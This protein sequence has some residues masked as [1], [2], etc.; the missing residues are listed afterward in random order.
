M[1]RRRILVSAYA[2]EPGKGSE[3]GVGWQWCLQLAQLADLVVLT[4]A[5][6]RSAIEGS[7][8]AEL[9]GKISFIYHDPPGWVLR[10][11]HREK[12][13]YWFYLLWQWGA[14][15]RARHAVR[16]QRF[17]YT[18]HLTFGSIWMPTFFHRLPVPFIWGPIGGGEAVPLSVIPALPP[19]GRIVQYLRHVLMACVPFNPLLTNVMARAAVI[20]AR[21]EDTQRVIPRRYAAKLRVI[22]ETAMSDE[23]LANLSIPVALPQERLLRVIYTGRLVALKNVQAGMHAVARAARAGARLEFVIVGDGPMRGNLASLAG[24]LGIGDSVKFRGNLPHSEVLA[25][26]AN[27]DVY[28]FPSL[29]EGGVWSLMEAMAARL[30]VICVE[31]SGMKIITDA[32]CAIR[33]APESQE[34]MISGFTQALL[35]LHGS[36]E[37]RRE[38]GANARRRIEREFRWGKKAEMMQAVFSEL[39]AV[40]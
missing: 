19:R 4:R 2:C 11:K 40:R 29:K 13:L 9:A 37:S 36:P 10:R 5:N 8:P 24:Q 25:E 30:P 7:L 21:T 6:N 22:L 16:E 20:L 23:L 39:E 15:Y 32:S 17:D 3:Q 27:S 1:T 34:Q 35:S 31:S 18:M 26:L 14:Y 12:G 28:L 38:M 33:V